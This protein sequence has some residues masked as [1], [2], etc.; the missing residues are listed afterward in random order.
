MPTGEPNWQIMC[1]VV[2]VMIGLGALASQASFEFELGTGALHYAMY[3]ITTVL[4]R[5]IMGMD[6]RWHT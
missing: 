2:P 4:L 6:P 5:F 1:A 3:L